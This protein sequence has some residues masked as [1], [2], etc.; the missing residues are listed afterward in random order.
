MGGEWDATDKLTLRA[1]Y[2]FSESPIRE[3]TYTPAI[4]SSDRNMFSVG[5]TYEFNDQV[6]LSVSYI[7]TIFDDTEIET[8]LQ[9]AFLGDYEV[10]WQAVTTSLTYRW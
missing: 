4:P 9:P 8:N 6:S 5:A 1:G 3:I 10:N 2:L 7:Q